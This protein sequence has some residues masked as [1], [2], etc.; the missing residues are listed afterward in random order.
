MD[1][2]NSLN[3]DLN[4][5]RDDW[6]SWSPQMFLTSLLYELRTPVMVIKGYT[7]ILSNE[8]MKEHHPR[9]IESLAKVADEMEKIFDGIAEYRNE[10]QRRHNT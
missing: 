7:Q 3:N 9:A 8:A 1:D 2:T 6:R 5:N 4:N 10:L